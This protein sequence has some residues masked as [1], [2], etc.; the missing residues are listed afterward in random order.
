MGA[1]TKQKGD[2]DFTR[3]HCQDREVQKQRKE[4]GSQQGPAVPGQQPVFLKPGA[5]S[6]CPNW[7]SGL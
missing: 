7:P 2:S 5:I 4:Q 6:P 3:A 1:D